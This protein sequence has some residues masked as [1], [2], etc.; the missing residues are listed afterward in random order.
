MTPT[1]ASGPPGLEGI[2]TL[3]LPAGTILPSG[4]SS[5]AMNQWEGSLPYLQLQRVTGLYDVADADDP[6][7][8]LVNQI[9]E[10]PYPRLRRGKTL[11]YSGLVR[12]AS[13]DDMR[14]LIAT[15]RAIASS[16]QDTTLTLAYD[17][18]YAGGALEFTACG[19]PIAFTCDDD[20]SS[21]SPQSVPSPYQRGFTLTYRMRDPRF[22][23]TSVAAATAAAAGGTSA[24]LTVAGLAPSEPT[25]VLTG[26][27]SG[28][29]VTIQHLGQGK[30][31]AMRPT[32]ALASG[33]TLTVN[34]AQRTASLTSAGVTTDV[35]G[36]IDYTVTDWWDEDAVGV[37]AGN[38]TLEALH[39]ASWTVSAQ[40]AVW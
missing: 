23:A 35:S 9:G 21:F 36:S 6:R 12:A 14:S 2:H 17:A 24:V 7:D 3:H 13:L 34:F 33:D 37:G 4:A 29:A 15:L 19:Q 11:T 26:P 22:Y 16:T 25:F 40:P 39:V 27:S 38:N 28:G 8:N 1:I 30:T 18:T 10:V 31:L 5:V 32:F 20:Q